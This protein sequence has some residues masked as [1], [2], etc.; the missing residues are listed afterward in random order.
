MAQYS[1]IA[2]DGQLYGPVDE[3]GLAEWVRQGRVGPD[4]MLHCHDNNG[5]YQAAAVPALRPALGL[6]PQQVG[7]LLNPH[8]QQQ[9]YAQPAAAAYGGDVPVNYQ[10]P[11]TYGIGQVHHG[12]SEFPVA[13]AVALSIFVPLF[14]LIYYGLAHGNMPKRRHDDPSAG[15]AIGFM[16]IPFFNL[17]WVCFFWTRLC[18]RI[19]DERAAVGLPPTAPRSLVVAILWTYLGMFIPI[20][21]LL[22][23]VALV[24]ML[25]IALIQIQT[26]INELCRATARAR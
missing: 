6:S 21:N 10:T 9:A 7:Q 3:N 16:F 18:T 26:S 4:T 20:L 2:Q 15:K 1:V 22:V 17:Y 13:G 5:R 14:P 23:L 12:L 25:L 11:G 24:V 8:Q 19:N